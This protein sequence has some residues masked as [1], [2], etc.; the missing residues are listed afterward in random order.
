MTRFPL[1]TS[2]ITSI[3]DLL[4]PRSKHAAQWSVIS[5]AC[6]FIVDTNDQMLADVM[7]TLKP[8]LWF[9]DSA[10]TVYLADMD[11]FL[12]LF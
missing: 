4:L 8:E 9:K 6:K 12:E 5:L 2:L 3:T 10:V 7:S 11:G 1:C